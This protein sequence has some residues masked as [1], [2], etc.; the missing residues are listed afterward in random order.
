MNSELSSDNA[1]ID[2]CMKMAAMF[3]D[4]RWGSNNS[5][6]KYWVLIEINP[7]INL[8]KLEIGTRH[9]DGTEETPFATYK[10]NNDGT[11]HKQTHV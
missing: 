11:Y 8:I 2:N 4:E 1:G 7:N 10:F 9:L 5:E 6:S 3:L